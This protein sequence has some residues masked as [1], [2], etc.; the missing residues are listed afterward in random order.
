MSLEPR[1]I[2]TVL[3][4]GACRATVTTTFVNTAFAVGACLGV[5]VVLGTTQVFRYHKRWWDRLVRTAFKEIDGD[6][7]G[8]I[9]EHE[10]YGAVLQLYTKLPIRCPPPTHSDILVVFHQLDEDQSNT[11]DFEEF[12]KV[13]R[14]LMTRV[15]IRVTVAGFFMVFSPIL[16]S[17]LY[18]HPPMYPSLQHIH[19]LRCSGDLIDSTMGLRAALT[20][21]FLCLTKPALLLVDWV[22]IDVVAD[23][24]LRQSSSKEQSASCVDADAAIKW[25]KMALAKQAIEDY[26]DDK[27]DETELRRRKDD[28]HKQA[29]AEHAQQL[30]REAPRSAARIKQ[31]VM[32]KRQATMRTIDPAPL[33]ANAH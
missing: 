19:W 17:V 16:A 23:W 27:I 15:S 32:E 14:T 4:E 8:L 26:F 24:M 7:S 33:L 31:M 13:C 20:L 18:H 30:E 12:A 6:G 9:E 1:N 3:H 29:A 5:L 2:S 28:A 11:L 22:L 21:V 25:R 10:L